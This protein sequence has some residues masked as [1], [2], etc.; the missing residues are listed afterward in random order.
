MYIYIHINY[1]D[2]PHHSWDAP[3]RTQGLKGLDFPT[4]KMTFLISH[5]ALVNINGLVLLGKF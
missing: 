3:S 5:P 2:I 4:R 1:G